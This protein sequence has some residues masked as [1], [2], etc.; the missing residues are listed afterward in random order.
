MSSLSIFSGITDQEKEH[1]FH[2]F[3]P[4]T[5]VFF[6]GETIPLFYAYYKVIDQD[7]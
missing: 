5:K 6:E 4:V 7:Y 1:M 3:S 2:C